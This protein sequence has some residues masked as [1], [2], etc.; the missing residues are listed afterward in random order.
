[1]MSPLNILLAIM[2]FPSLGSVTLA[3]PIIKAK[4]NI[5]TEIDFRSPS[6]ATASAPFPK[7]GLA[8]N[9]AAYIQHWTGTDSQVNWAYNW[10]SWMPGNFP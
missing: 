10:D 4:V 6:I 5:T 8:F 7:R 2:A 1:M 9:N 3:S